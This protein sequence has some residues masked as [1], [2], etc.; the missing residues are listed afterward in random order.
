MLSL[1]FSLRLTLALSLSLALALTLALSLSLA[2]GRKPT[3]DL[4]QGKTYTKRLGAH[5]M[6][7]RVPITS[8]RRLVE[9]A[10]CATVRPHQTWLARH[11]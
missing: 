3:W 10:G 2:L 6:Q 11:H 5:H 9:R 1:A 4:H 7:C 8:R